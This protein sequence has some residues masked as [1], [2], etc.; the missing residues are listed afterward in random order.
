M[1]FL[2][3]INAYAVEKQYEK[4]TKEASCLIKKYAISSNED[5][6]KSI[7]NNLSSLS[8][9][10]PDNINVIR[11]YSGVLSSRGEYKKAI[12]VLEAFNQKHKN[13]SLLLHECMLKDRVGDYKPSCYK[14]VISL[15]RAGGVNDID[16]LMALFMMDDKD[17]NKEKDIYMKKMNDNHDLEVFKNK[18]EKLL[19]VFYPN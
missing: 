2:W 18:K 10:N 14:K 3:V 5:I 19:K 8:D 1:T 7:L 11:M 6:K 9:D 13:T 16:Y 15:K 12:S 17:F 4:S